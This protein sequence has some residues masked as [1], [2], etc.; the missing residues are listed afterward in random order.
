L[1]A[2]AESKMQ[3]SVHRQTAEK[4]VSKAE[5]VTREAQNAEKKPPS[6]RSRSDG[7]RGGD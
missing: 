7:A 4:N 2:E 1:A 6:E 3:R 5:T